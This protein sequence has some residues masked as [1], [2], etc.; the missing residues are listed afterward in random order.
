MLHI[1][2]L[3]P[4]YLTAQQVKQPAGTRKKWEEIR[5]QNGYQRSE[6]YKG[7]QG[8][9]YFTPSSIRENRSTYGSPS[10]TTQPYQGVPYNSTHEQQGKTPSNP[11][12]PGGNGTIEEDPNIEPSENIDVPEIDSP[13]SPNL[14]NPKASMEFWKWL[15]IILLVIAVAYIIYYTVKNRTPAQKRVAFEPII[16]DMNPAEIEKSEL[17]MR[18]DEARASGNYK[19]CVRIYFLF[20]MK[21]LIE[22]KWIFWK[23]EKTNMHYIIEMQG[24]N[25]TRSFEE[26]VAIYDLVWYGDYEIGEQAYREFEPTLERAYQTI[27]NDQ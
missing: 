5:E 14:S 6:Q 11:N 15:G 3:L 7:P 9:N 8:D 24:R 13:K 23:K 16:E 12:G 4:L 22:R 25:C 20:A 17:E 19:E 18:L 26:I 21:E 10:G 27:E 2:F 1:L